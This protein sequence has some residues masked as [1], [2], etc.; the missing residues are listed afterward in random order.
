MRCF[1]DSNQTI[2]ATGE[3][4][5]YLRNMSSVCE[6]LVV[7]PGCQRIDFLEHDWSDHALPFYSFNGSTNCTAARNYYSFL[8][9]PPAFLILII[10]AC[11]LLIVLTVLS[12]PP[13][14]CCLVDLVKM[15][16]K[17]CLVDLVNMATPTIHKVH[18]HNFRSA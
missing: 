4:M 1:W 8:P 14:C 16:K 9:F 5:Q 6:E 2:D 17:C 12:L 18:I 3:V 7:L 10:P 13:V 11:S 15:V